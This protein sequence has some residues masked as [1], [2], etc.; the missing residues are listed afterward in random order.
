[1]AAPTTTAPS[2]KIAITPVSGSVP[3]CQPNLMP[4]HINYNGP[5]AVT[6][7]MRVEKLVGNVERPEAHGCEQVSA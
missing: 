5:A 1:M 6:T 4:F 3:S 7:F 2:V